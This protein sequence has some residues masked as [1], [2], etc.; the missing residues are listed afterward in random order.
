[1][2]WDEIKV[3]WKE[4]S[5]ALLARWNLLTEDDLREVVGDRHLLAEKLS[6]VYDLSKAEANRQ[7]DEWLA[8]R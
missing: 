4:F 7:I 2:K 5:S 3:H 1:M 8:G 6:E